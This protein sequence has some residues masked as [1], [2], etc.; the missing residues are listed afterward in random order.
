LGLDEQLGLAILDL[1]DRAAHASKQFR[2]TAVRI[3]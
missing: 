3:G 2:Y 1:L